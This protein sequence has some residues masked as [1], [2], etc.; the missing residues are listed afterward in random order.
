MEEPV[1]SEIIMP[2]FQPSPQ[3]ESAITEFVKDEL[4]LY[5]LTL[6]DATLVACPSGDQVLVIK[7]STP[8]FITAN[9]ALPLFSCHRSISPFL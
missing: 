9:Q 5:G 4:N 3:D 1:D 2:E 7:L 8:D 6:E